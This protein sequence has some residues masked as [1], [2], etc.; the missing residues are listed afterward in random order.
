MICGG[1]GVGAIRFRDFSNED[2]VLYAGNFGWD[3]DEFYRGY[4]FAERACRLLLPFVRS[5]G[6]EQ[7][8]ITCDPENVASRRTCERLGA[9]L[10]EIVDIPPM[11]EMYLDG[12]R[13]KCRYLLK[14]SPAGA[15]TI[16]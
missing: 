13:Q 2:T 4:G 6:H 3:V 10:V 12:E 8:W 14:V 15:Q 7:I 5:C 16:L 9:R 1:L 11:H